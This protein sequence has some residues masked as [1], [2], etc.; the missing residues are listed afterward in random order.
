MGC[1]I[2]AFVELVSKED[3]T[4]VSSIAEF[5][6]GRDYRLFTVLAGVR[7]SE[8]LLFPEPKGIPKSLGWQTGDKYYMVVVP[9]NEPGEEENTVKRSS[10]E[11]YVKDGF[12][13]WEDPKNQWRISSP[14]WH[15][16][17]YLNTKELEDAIQ[18]Y[19]PANA[20]LEGT[21]EI[22][23]VLSLMKTLDQDNKKTEARFVFWFD[24]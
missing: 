24:N 13:T 2:H 6:L 20:G 14:D 11:E 5:N 8:Q 18:V 17:S 4:R 21:R 15:T 3:Q 22:R 16:P 19:G 10:A 7:V 9:D 1:D 12:S 23:G